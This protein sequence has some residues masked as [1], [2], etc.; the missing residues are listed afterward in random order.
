VGLIEF[1]IIIF[2]EI[3]QQKDR[4]NFVTF[5]G[6][7]ALTPD[8]RAVFS[9]L[10]L[11]RAG[12]LKYVHTRADEK[13]AQPKGLIHVVAFEEL[14][15]LAEI[16]R[17]FKRFGRGLDVE[18]DCY[19][20]KTS[21]LPR[22]GALSIG[23]GFNNLTTALSEECNGL[24]EIRYEAPDGVEPVLGLADSTDHVTIRDGTNDIDPRNLVGNRHDYAL[25]ARVI[26]RSVPFVIC[27]GHTARGTAAA[28]QGYISTKRDF[29]L[30]HMAAILSHV[31]DRHE[32]AKLCATFFA[33]FQR[34][35]DSKITKSPET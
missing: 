11:E 4:D 19:D 29:Q 20:E 27:A 16:D 18:L 22:A 30:N 32:N 35:A 12:K 14:T 9:K 15:S 21:T 24:F 25:I 8:Y 6:R 31:W 1:L 10:E 28:Y 13:K 33:P 5:F 2:E 7:G 23:L 26:Y 3:N 17:E 34:H